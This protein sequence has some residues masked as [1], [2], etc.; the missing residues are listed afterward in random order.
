MGILTISSPCAVPPTTSICASSKFQAGQLAM[1]YFFLVPRR[2]IP[3]IS[4]M[5]F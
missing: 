3:P 4:F 1:P 5:F 2:T